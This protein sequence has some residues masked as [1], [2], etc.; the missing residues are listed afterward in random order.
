MQQEVNVR[1]GVINEL[2]RMAFEKKWQIQ[3][4]YDYM[5]FDQ[6][7]AIKHCRKKGNGWIVEKI[8]NIPGKVVNYKNII[9]RG[10][11]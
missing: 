10:G 1:Y 2:D 9:F 7:D 11:N 4:G 5:T 8:Y 3:A 6:E